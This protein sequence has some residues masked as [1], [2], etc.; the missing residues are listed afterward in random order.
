MFMAA[1]HASNDNI[2]FALFYNKIVIALLFV[3]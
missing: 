3:I 2:I 1:D